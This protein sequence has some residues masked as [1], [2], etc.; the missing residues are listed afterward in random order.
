MVPDRHRCAKYQPLSKENAARGEVLDTASSQNE[1]RAWGHP[2]PTRGPGHLC[3]EC[4]VWVCLTVT[5]T[6]EL[7]LLCV[8]REL[9]GR[10]E[11]ARGITGRPTFHGCVG[12]WAVGKNHIHV[13]QLQPLQGSFQSWRRAGGSAVCVSRPSLGLGSGGKRGVRA[14][15]CHVEL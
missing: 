14:G 7:V 4:R 1:I 8:A 5:R 13:L 12:V 15:S 11:L 9:T 2:S 6:S 10:P 3:P